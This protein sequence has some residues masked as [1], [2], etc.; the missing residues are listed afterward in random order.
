MKREFKFRH[1]DEIAGTLV[2]CAVA[3]F[4]LGVVLAGRSQGWFEGKF[5][6]NIRFETQEGSFGLQEGA[7]VQVRNTVAGRVGK[8]MPIEG[9]L[10]GTTLIIKERFRPFITKDSVAK[11]KKKFGVAGD[12]YVEVVRGPGGMIV[13][14]ED[15]I[16]C[17]KDE[18]LMETAQKMLEELEKTMLPM[19]EEIERIVASAASIMSSVEKGEGIAG[20]VVGDSKLRDDLTHIVAHLESIAGEADKAVVEVGTLLSNEVNSVVGDVTVMADHARTMFTNDVARLTSNMHGLQDEATRT[21]KESRRLIEAIQRHWLFRKHV[22]EDSGTVALVPATLCMVENDAVSRALEETLVAARA[23]DETEGIAR[24]AYNLAVARLA[25]GDRASAETLNT[26]ARIAYR[27]A[28]KSGAATYLL[29]AELSRLV[30]E[31]DAAITLVK[32][33]I[34]ELEGGADK[35]TRVEAQVLL[36]TVYVDAEDIERAQEALERAERLNRRL[37]LPQYAAAIEG[38]RGRIALMQGDKEAAATAFTAQADHLR[39]AGALKTMVVALQETADVYRDLGMAASAAEFYYR[40]ANSLLA[41]GKTV[42]ARELLAQAQA[43]AEA[44]GDA[45]LQKRV[46]QLLEAPQ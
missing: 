13:D 16:R 10:L 2:I 37:E 12:S 28:G 22:K 30:R 17:A 41:Q 29:E 40:A 46:R 11:V 23:A 38:L 15:L 43:A 42:R 19:V 5:V 21:L 34:E 36:A 25:A 27:S 39:E 6:L 44:A 1:A 45:L 35:E 26:E 3:L 18:E 8:I 24:N 4:V 32:Q 33:A 7:I 31:F 14:D 9:G 20:A